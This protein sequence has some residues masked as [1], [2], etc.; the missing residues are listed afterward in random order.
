MEYYGER[1]KRYQT[2]LIFSGKVSAVF[3]LLRKVQTKLECLHSNLA[4]PCERE[5]V[6]QRNLFIIVTIAYV[7]KIYLLV[8]VNGYIYMFRVLWL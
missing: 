4:L 2:A 7:Y 3:F 5:K 8:I 6:T 1:Q